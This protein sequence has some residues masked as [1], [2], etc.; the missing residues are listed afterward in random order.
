MSKFQILISHAPGLE[1]KIKIDTKF[2]TFNTENKGFAS[3]QCGSQ[4]L[5]M[6]AHWGIVAMATRQTKRLMCRYNENQIESV[7]GS[8]NVVFE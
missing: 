3:D 4:G 5:I 2:S 6:I 1:N 7:F 8:S